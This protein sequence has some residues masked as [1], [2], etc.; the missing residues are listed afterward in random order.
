ML[1][2]YAWVG[3]V[4]LRNLF[5]WFSLSPDLWVVCGRHPLK[6]AVHV[7]PRLIKGKDLIFLPRCLAERFSF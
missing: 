5:S 1:V 7:L 2:G 3:T 6:R 4:H